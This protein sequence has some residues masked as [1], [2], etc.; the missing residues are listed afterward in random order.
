MSAIIGPEFP[1]IL[2]PK[3]DEA[4]NKIKIVV[5]DWRWYPNDTGSP[6]QLFNQALVRAVRRCVCVRAITNFPDIVKTLQKEGVEAKKLATKNLIHAKMIIIDDRIVV[7][8]SHNITAPAFSTNYE[9]STIIENEEQAKEY[10]QFFDKL[11][12]S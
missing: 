11:W 2:I 10:S 7:V 3:I 8:G 6:V 4:K 9:V 5:F 12:Q 1:K